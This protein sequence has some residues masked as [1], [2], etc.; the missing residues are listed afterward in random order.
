M[1]MTAYR[2]ADIFDGQVRRSG[3]ALLVDEGHVSGIVP[4]TDMPLGVDVVD[5]PGGL[6][7]PGFIDVQVNGGGGVLL[8]D[9]PTVAGIR[10]ICE[11]HARFGSTALM[12]TVITDRPENT[13]AA[14]EAVDAAMTE[15]VPG[16][17]GIHVEGP[18]LST[19]RKGAHDPAL[20]RTMSDDDLARFA[21]TTVRPMILTVATESVTPHQIGVLAANGI[22][23]SIG[24][25]DATFEDAKR[26]FESGAR[27]VTHLFNAMSQLG[28]R[29]PGLVG[30]AL[31]TP[32]VWC[33]I[34]ADGYHV[35]PAAIGTALRA[36]RGQG[37]MMAITDAMP[38]VGVEA[39]VFELNGRTVRRSDGRLTLDDGTLAGS[40]LTMIGAVQY[41][42][43]AIGVPLEEALRMASLY[44]ATFLGLQ[45]ERGAL[46]EGLRA[47]MVWMD[48][49]LNLRGVLIGG[50]KLPRDG[51]EDA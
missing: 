18:F 40:D 39:G 41:L 22:I 46:T 1:A 15:G 50:R 43:G 13:F 37:T 47:D 33:G 34:I 23:V 5:L 48:D 24:H 10:A 28:H 2:G 45:G 12:P 7:A 19:A 17:I 21:A 6:I 51:Q 31:E 29:S 3:H 4:Q 8:N 25:S 16:C 49:A 30:A 36:K 38:T 42:V 20:I 26:A 44:P 35:H 27:G 9:R 11:A 32:G 14:I